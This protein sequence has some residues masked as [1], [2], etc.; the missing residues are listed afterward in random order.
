MKQSTK[1]YKRPVNVIDFLGNALSAVTVAAAVSGVP[2][3]STTAALPAGI[4]LESTA[5]VSGS[6]T[7]AGRVSYSSGQ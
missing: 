6:V 4:A 7:M 3:L 2:L 5:A 1:N